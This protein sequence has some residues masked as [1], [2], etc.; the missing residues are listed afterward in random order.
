MSDRVR[1]YHESTKHRTN[2]YAP[3]PGFLDWDCQPDPFRRYLHAPVLQMPFTPEVIG[4]P[5]QTLFEP[6]PVEISDCSLASL[7]QFLEL[8][9]G[10]SAW[11][12]AGSDR[13][14][15]RM[16]PSSG[17]LHPTEIYLI[18]WNDS[19]EAP[20][21][22]VYHYAVHDH[23][24]ECRCRYSTE[25]ATEFRKQFPES[26]GALGLS[27]IL[28]R[29]EWKYG[30]RAYRYC[31]LDIGHALG[32]ARFSAA[33]LGW[34]L[35]L[36]DGISDHHLA[37]L[38]GLDRDEDFIDVEREIPE[39]LVLISNSPV[40]KISPEW[41]EFIL[42]ANWY[43]KASRLSNER[44]QWPQSRS[45][46]PSLEKPATLAT[47]RH[48]H[49]TNN[50]RLLPAEDAAVIIRRRRSVQRM[51][52]EASSLD[53]AAFLRLLQQVLPRSDI[54]PFDLFNIPPSISLLLY[55]HQVKGL[56]H[57]LYLLVRSP[58]HYA[59]LESEMNSR[60][61]TWMPVPDMDGLYELSTPE[62]V[63]KIA[64]RC[65]CHQSIAGHGAFAVGML[66]DYSY[67][68][69]QAGPWAYRWLHWEAGLIGQ[70]LYLEAENIGLQG[71]GIG[72]YFDDEVHDLLGLKATQGH[73]QMVYHF[74]IGKAMEDQRLIS[75]PP[76][77]HLQERL[78]KPDLESMKHQI[79][80]TWTARDAIKTSLDQ[81]QLS[82]WEGL[83]R[84]D[85]ID[86]LL[87]RLDSQYKQRWDE[88]NQKVKTKP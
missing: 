74:T 54:P 78:P 75:E 10:L 22:G 50:T 48:N 20:E 64:S 63:R 49:F 52:K 70:L 39:A 88:Q 26:T 56:K 23:V 14:A 71:T 40:D 86:A 38:L 62:D 3:G 59:R 51:D 24:L 17:N 2:A 61:F 41:P 57:G 21:P 30:S 82:M 60:S 7:A 69:A 34:Q 80:S 53:R 32:A 81:A 65:C 9:F 11:K 27:S 37:S 35:K 31:Q 15:L 87:S 77:A 84:L 16:N 42:N 58:D 19:A 79:A 13:W 43:G 73:W 4:R 25:T 68:L 67:T 28:W 6:L 36:L 5:Y 47:G 29:E 8:G 66:A 45:L 1:H 12:S 55:V 83:S 46:L 72:C 76:F 33:T 44:L 18:I 85:R